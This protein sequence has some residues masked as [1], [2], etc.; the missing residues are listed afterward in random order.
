MT[1]L[2]LEQLAELET[3]ERELPALTWR[4]CKDHPEHNSNSG[5]WGI[6]DADQHDAKL[7]LLSVGEQL[8][9]M[10]NDLPALIAAAKRLAELESALEYLLVRDNWYLKN[11]CGISYPAETPRNILGLAKERGWKGLEP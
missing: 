3:L 7:P 11:T 10:R 4:G 6:Y 8:V 2:T 1:E 9:G 5:C